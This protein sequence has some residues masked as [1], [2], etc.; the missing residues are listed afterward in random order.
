[1]ARIPLDFFVFVLNKGMGDIQLLHR[2]MRQKERPSRGTTQDHTLADWK[3]KSMGA[4]CTMQVQDWRGRNEKWR[5]VDKKK[6]KKNE[7]FHV[8]K[9]FLR[10]TGCI[11]QWLERCYAGARTRAWE[12]ALISHSSSLINLSSRTHF[13]R[14]FGARFAAT[15]TKWYQR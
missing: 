2:I 3:R 11:V 14:I 15:I 1:M 5:T 10:L 9:I 7:K 13:H 8:T 12:S 4:G 6:K